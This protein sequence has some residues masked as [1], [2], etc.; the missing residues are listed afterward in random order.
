LEY[1]ILKNLQADPEDQPSQVLP[2]VAG[3]NVPEGQAS[4]RHQ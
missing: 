3:P 2:H 4:W 1:L